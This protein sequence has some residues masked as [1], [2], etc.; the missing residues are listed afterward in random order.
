MK[1]TIPITKETKD[2]LKKYGKM[3]ETWDALLNR[4]LDKCE[5]RGDKED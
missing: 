5:R 4:I 1:T 2:R 3:G